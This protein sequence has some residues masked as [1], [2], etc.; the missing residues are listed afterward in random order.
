MKA[1]VFWQSQHALVDVTVRLL[2]RIAKHALICNLAELTVWVGHSKA[3]VG[4]E[5]F[6][7]AQLSW[8]STPTSSY[9]LLYSASHDTIT[10]E[11]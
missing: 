5:P 10:L 9:T 8:P 4:H 11:E 6:G 3:G 1:K 7:Q 2:P